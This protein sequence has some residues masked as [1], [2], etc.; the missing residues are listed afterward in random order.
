MDRDDPLEVL[1]AIETL[2]T[3]TSKC[4]SAQLIVA[5]LLGDVGRF[6]QAIRASESA[7]LLAAQGEDRGRYMR[8]ENLKLQFSIRAR[9]SEAA[10]AFFC[11]DP[12]STN[13]F[14]ST[15]DDLIRL[16]R[17]E[18]EVESLNR[19]SSARDLLRAIR[20]G[21]SAAESFANI[22]RPEHAARLCLRI[23]LGPAVAVG[24]YCQMIELAESASS[25]S[26]RLE[27]KLESL[28]VSALAAAL[29]CDFAAHATYLKRIDDEMRAAQS[30][31]MAA[32]VSTSSL[33]SAARLGN[34]DLARF[35]YRHLSEVLD[36][37]DDLMQTLCRSHASVA[38][39]ILGD[40]VAAEALLMSLTSGDHKNVRYAKENG[41]KFELYVRGSTKLS[42]PLQEAIDS[43]DIIL[44]RALPG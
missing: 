34:E 11:A 43:G 17:T 7:R 35:E 40:F 4:A 44:H 13:D 36:A 9:I 3:Q 16:E 27:V 5:Q 30:D 8:A 6:D 42:K 21:E 1:K 38:F 20:L 26:S 18:S 15:V 29:S 19:S 31:R 24:R 25:L 41:L 22:G 33:I 28:A 10:G 14:G 37:C 39:A 23:A 12:D 32:L 2:G